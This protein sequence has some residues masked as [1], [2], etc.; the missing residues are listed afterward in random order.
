[1]K[2]I[3]KPHSHIK[4]AW[5]CE[6]AVTQFAALQIVQL[7]TGLVLLNLKVIQTLL[8]PVQA[9]FIH[10]TLGYVGLTSLFGGWATCHV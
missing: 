4:P 9:L 5:L 2:K 6:P 8:L 1:M 10:K 3:C 7:R